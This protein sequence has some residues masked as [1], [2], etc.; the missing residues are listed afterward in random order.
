MRGGV[1]E[2]DAVAEVRI[3][4]LVHRDEVGIRQES[5]CAGW[6]FGT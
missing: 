1:V 5:P 6:T 4:P 2:V 3:F